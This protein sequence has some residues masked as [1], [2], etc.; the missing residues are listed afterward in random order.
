M[1]LLPGACLR[2]LGSNLMM[3]PAASPKILETR[4]T[5]RVRIGIRGLL[6]MILVMALILGWIAHMRREV[7]E[8]EALV[9]ELASEHIIPNHDW[10]T[11]LCFVLMKVLSTDSHSVERRCARWLSPEW[12]YH[13]LGFNAGRR[14]DEEV[15]PIVA[16][17]QRLG[18]VHEVHFHGGTLND[19]RL[20]SI[21]DYPYH[22]LGPEGDTCTFKD[23]PA[24]E[25][26]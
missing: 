12:F 6:G 2:S 17:L 19:L 7:R 10:P 25:G 15:A 13:R 11:P 23:Y 4:N 16:K 5:R 24:P 9:A 18:T 14:K 20:F 3:N 8:Q 22:N 26:R 1:P 21:G